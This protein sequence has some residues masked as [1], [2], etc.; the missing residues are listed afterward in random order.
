MD[1]KRHKK[2]I[3]VILA[4]IAL[5]L[6]YVTWLFFTIQVVIEEEGIQLIKSYP[7]YAQ[8]VSKY[9]Q[10][11]VTVT[12]LDRHQHDIDYTDSGHKEFKT[13]FMQK[14]DP[15]F[16]ET[17]GCILVLR[18]YDEGYVYQLD[19]EFN[20]VHKVPIDVFEKQSEKVDPE[21]MEWFYNSLK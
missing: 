6:V 10:E 3:L 2:I 7:E 21:T 11:H 9:D 1:W 15:N 18:A 12:A 5:I 14:I 20:L 13:E 4:L 19:G 17:S 16:R 8:L